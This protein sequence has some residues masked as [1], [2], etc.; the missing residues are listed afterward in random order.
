[1]TSKVSASFPAKFYDG[2]ISRPWPAR[3]DICETELV[4]IRDGGDPPLTWALHETYNQDE[5]IKGRDLVLVNRRTPGAQL[6]FS[7]HDDLGVLLARLS[8]QQRSMSRISL[9]V[10]IVLALTV[11][12]IG[13][14]L[15]AGWAVRNS[16]AFIASIIPYSWERPIGEALVPQISEAQNY[17]ESHPCSVREQ[18]RVLHKLVA[19]LG[20]D[21]V[22]KDLLILIDPTSD[23]NAFA[24]PG[25][26]ML[27]N[28]GLLKYAGSEQEILGV[29]AH[30][31]GHLNRHHVM[32]TLVHSVGLR[33]L[34]TGMIGD[35]GAAGAQIF[36]L[37]YSRDHEREADQSA[38][39]YLNKVGLSTRALADF[40]ARIEKTHG[41]PKDLSDNDVV[42]Y[43]I[44]HPLL[45]ERLTIL[46]KGYAP[47]NPA[48]ASVL[49]REEFSLLKGAGL[50]QACPKETP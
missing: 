2:L 31:M 28:R 38:V 10:P 26:T 1:M 40:L 7:A 34:L 22:P 4:I 43:F 46:K 48:V 39:D 12:A 21:V 11:L 18:T 14:I 15:A 25:N 32:E 9:S 35:S 30:E 36:E 19:K 16:S 24:L 41:L 3:A 6:I 27:I 33:A 23:V 13:A 8:A 37:G 5:Y 17:Q 42:G 50:K 49:S 20:A 45:K 47:K 44:S 29:V